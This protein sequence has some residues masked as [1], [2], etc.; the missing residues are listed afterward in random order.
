MAYIGQ[1][2]YMV[3]DPTGEAWTNSFYASAPPQVQVII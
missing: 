2:A 1:S 3:M